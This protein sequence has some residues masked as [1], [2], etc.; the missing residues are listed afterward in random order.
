MSNTL[1]IRDVDS[2]LRWHIQGM[3]NTRNILAIKILVPCPLTDN[4]SNN[5]GI[6]ESILASIINI[7]RFNQSA[8]SN[9]AIMSAMGKTGENTTISDVNLHSPPDLQGNQCSQ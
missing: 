3:V 1:F 5:S 8:A 4:K 6:S 9:V 7:E 2:A